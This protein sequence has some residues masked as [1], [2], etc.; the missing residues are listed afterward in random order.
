MRTKLTQAEYDKIE[1]LMNQALSAPNKK[2]A[3]GYID[4]LEF[5]GNDFAGSVRNIL[6]ESSA[7]LKDAPSKAADDKERKEDFCKMD[8]YKLKAFIE[9]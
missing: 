4:Q 8:L 5:L 6:H 7:Y 3:K 1:N 9:K 2:A